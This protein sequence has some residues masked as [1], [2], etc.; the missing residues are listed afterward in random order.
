MCNRISNA[1]CGLNEDWSVAPGFNFVFPKLGRRYEANDLA[2]KS[3][4]TLH[5]LGRGRIW[6]L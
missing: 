5:F 6:I 3:G 2:V 1:Y 4:C